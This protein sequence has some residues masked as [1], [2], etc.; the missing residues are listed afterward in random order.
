[1]HFAKTFRAAMVSVALGASGAS[2]AGASTIF[3][4]SSASGA[5]NGTSWTDAYT[6][7]QTALT[8]AVATDE[9]WVAAGT[10]KPT[11]TTDRNFSFALKNGVGIYG[12]FAGTETMRSQR[13]PAANVTILSGDIGT[14]GVAT[15]NSYHVV[16]S[17]STVTAS[18]IL[19]GFTLTAGRADG[20]GDPTDR[21]GGAYINQGSPAFVGCT[22]SN[23][24]AGN[25]GAGVRVAAGSPSFTSC[26]FQGNFAGQAGAGLGAG[27]VGSMQIKGCV[28]RGNTVGSPCM[29]CAGGGGIE[30]TDNTTL[31]NSVVAQN[32]PNGIAFLGGGN[33]FIN[34]T[35]ANNASYGIAL[36][37]NPN[38]L[39]NSIVYGN[40][41]AAIFLGISGIV[42]VSYSDVQGGF[43]GTGNIN[44]NP[45]FLNAPSDLRL[46]SGSP[47]VDAA[48]NAAVPGGVTTDVAGVPRFFDDPGVVDTGAGTPPIVDM[49]AYER[50]PLSISAPSPSSQTVCAGG[51]VSFSV[52]ASGSPPLSYVWRKGGNVLSN[53]GSISG[54]TTTML[55]INPT[56][57]GD[58]GSY[59]AVVTDGFSQSL[60]SSAATLTVN[61]IPGAPVASNNGPI[62]TG[63]T[64]Q[65]SASTIA[66]ATYSWTGPNSFTSN[67]QNPSIPSATLAA[68]GTYNVTATVNA[69]TSSAGTTNAVVNSTPSAVI[70]AASSVCSG[71]GGHAA[72][73]PDAGVGA[74]YTWTI[75]NGTITGGAGTRSITFTSGVSGTVTL[76]VTVQASG[77]CSAMSS[78]M[79]TI[80]PPGC[81]GKFFTLVPCR[82]VDTRDAVGPWGGPAL[83]GG[84]AREFTIVGRCAIPSSARSVSLNVTVVLPTTSG[85]F[86]LYPGGTPLPLVSVLN[87]AAGQIKANNA[88]APLSDVGTLSVFCG[89]G[90]GTAHLLIDVNGY[91]E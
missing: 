53:G 54:A 34:V 17:D 3:V 51:S 12:G 63:Q 21:G 80:L 55:T 90:S 27:S 64:L 32:S 23:N 18:G 2:I 86:T 49:G 28:F 83:V 26:T 60:A 62:C 78:K 13:N 7:L 36:L 38:S 4:R 33:S 75:M 20:A 14:V 43:A 52:T 65:L 81:P 22:F 88:I 39:V 37:Q 84:A 29:F 66:S 73:V 46:G 16:T 25:R 59:D 44:A 89:Q 68:A 61:A 1:V 67:S 40:P 8:A 69:C 77:G 87:Y 35:V 57:P 15:D 24:Y 70:T 31:V 48:S 5:N 45:L 58:S 19:D 76:G 42:T 50:V 71:S 82:V 9:I 30:A 85:Y 11:A 56:A 47:A 6:S 41:T 79:V 10:Y 72:S 74:T 91:F